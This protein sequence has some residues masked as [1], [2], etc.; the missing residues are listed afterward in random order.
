MTAARS[1][2]V[3]D[4]SQARRDWAAWAIGRL[5]GADLQPAVTPLFE[6][7]CPE[8][9]GIRIVIKDE[10][11]H[12]SG[13]LKHRLAHSLLTRA[14]CSGLIGQ[15]STIVEASSGSTAI[16]LAWFARPLGLKLVAVIPSTSA[17]A[18]VAAIRW[19]GGE[20]VKA[21]PRQDLCEVAEHVATERGGYF[22]NQFAH[23][24]EATDWRGAS[25]ATCLFEQV[26]AL[27]A[28][29]PDWIVVGAGTGGTSATIGRHIRYRP[30]LSTT[31]LC[32]VDPEHSAYFHAFV[33]G[34]RNHAGRPGSIVEGIGRTRVADSFAAGVVDQMLA[35]PDIA[36]V[37]G[38]HWLEQR[39]GRRFGPST[40]TNMVGVLLLAQHMARNGERGMIATLAC[41]GGERYDQTIYDPA[42]LARQGLD[43]ESWRDLP[44]RTEQFAPPAV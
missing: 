11:A 12:P 14:I 9:P 27:G 4:C 7:D 23:A 17:P 2:S 6:I 10:T 3:R 1:L 21:G 40:G 16:S 22:I 33:T 29:M 5:E 13:S 41:D 32:V 8:V 35:I 31:R 19:A 26:R 24:A 38:A 25:I 44:A 36:S 43:L 39:S 42:W 28:G 18:K 34:D 20:V 15:G 37:A 30:E